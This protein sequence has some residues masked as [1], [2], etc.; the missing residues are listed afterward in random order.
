MTDE[1][2]VP[3]QLLA[4]EWGAPADILAA[5]LGDKVITDGLQIRHAR[6]ADAHELLAQRKAREE[7]RRQEEQAHRAAMA[8]QAEP[9]RARVAAL[10]AQ[11][12]QMRRD[13]Q[14]DAS[15]P[16]FVAMAAGENEARLSPA[17]RRMDGWLSGRSEGYTFAGQ[18]RED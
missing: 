10:Q 14:I 11:Q 12:R 15:T 8:A 1:P 7:A 4:A 16:A 9:I 2:L 3:L 6:V 18:P 13:G 5:E 17:S